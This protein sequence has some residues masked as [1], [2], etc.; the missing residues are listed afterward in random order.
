[1]TSEGLGEI[2]E[3]DFE[4]TVNGGLSVGS[5]MRRPWSEDSHRREGIFLKPF[6]LG[7]GPLCNSQR[8][9]EQKCLPAY[10]CYV[11]F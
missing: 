7:W 2:F 11:Y 1:M 3:G 4:N 10:L 8:V 6:T 5:S 9:D